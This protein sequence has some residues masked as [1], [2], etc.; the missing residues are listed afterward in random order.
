[1]SQQQRA[2]V[3]MVFWGLSGWF[4]GYEASTYA[5]GMPREYGMLDL[6]G[7]ASLATLL[8]TLLRSRTS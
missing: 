2:A 6:L 5:H 1:M 7:L 4:A 3:W 8:V